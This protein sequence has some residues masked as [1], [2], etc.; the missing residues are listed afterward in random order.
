MDRNV[1]Q[2]FTYTFKRPPGIS[3]EAWLEAM[4][5]PEPKPW[6]LRDDLAAALETSYRLAD[7]A[8]RA[9][10][11]AGYVIAR[12]DQLHADEEPLRWNDEEWD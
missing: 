8:L 2:E 1:T 5:P 7:D 6:T 4:K 3:K 10:R 11:E 12:P 9:I